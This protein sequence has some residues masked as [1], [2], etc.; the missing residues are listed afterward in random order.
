MSMSKKKKIFIGI[1][2]ALAIVITVVVIMMMTGGGISEADHK[3]ADDTSDAVDDILG[4]PSEIKMPDV[5]WDDELVS[6]TSTF[7]MDSIP[8]M[9][10]A[11][12]LNF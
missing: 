1:G 7:V 8:V 6:D 2:A 10:D 12:S 4:D 3:A 9:D 11:D 5:D